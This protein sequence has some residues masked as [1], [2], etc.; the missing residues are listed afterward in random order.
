MIKTKLRFGALVIFGWSLFAF[1]HGD[2]RVIIGWDSVATL[3][4]GKN[5]L[6]FVLYDKKQKKHL[7]D[8]D[9]KVTHTQKVHMF[10]TDRA[11]QEFHHLHPTYDPNTEKWSTTA[12]LPVNGEYSVWTQ[13]ELVADGDE[14]TSALEVPIQIAGGKPANP[15][16]TELGDMRTGAEGYSSIKLGAGRIVALRIIQLE[17]DF[18]RNDGTQPDL[19]T[20]LGAKAHVIGVHL[21]SQTL[22]HTH[23][24]D[25]GV[26]N[27]LMLHGMF[28]REG[29]YRLWIQ[30]LDGGKLRAIPLSV[31]VSK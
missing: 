6:L 8:A 20:Y 28:P 13:G 7:Q 22:I 27:Q 9:I 16:P 26:P 3:P 5:N 30:F 25:H 1:G 15:V 10:V 12:D 24:M 11:H 2:D 4:A 23:A 18:S 14:F 31:R 19:G 29:D 21:D 17:L